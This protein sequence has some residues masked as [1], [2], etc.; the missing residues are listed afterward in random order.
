[1]LNN[2]PQIHLKLLQ[3]ES[4][5]KTVE[6]PGG[7]IGN[8]IT[9]KIKNVSKNLETFTNENGKEIPKER[10]MSPGKKQEIIDDLRSK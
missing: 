3:K 1:M 10:Y 4:F 7:L 2:L 9:D 6:A 8:Q 5:Q